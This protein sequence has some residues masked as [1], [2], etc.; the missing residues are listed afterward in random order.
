MYLY[1]AHENNVAEFLLVLDIFNPPHIP[2]YGSFIVVEVHLIDGVY[3]L[4]VIFCRIYDEKVGIILHVTREKCLSRIIKINL[5]ELS[6]FL[7][8][9]AYARSYIVDSFII[10]FSGLWIKSKSII[11]LPD[12]LVDLNL[13]VFFM[14]LM[15]S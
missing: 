11:N 3:G 7:N 8:V 5:I 13:R 4:K 6:T 12:I 2:T 15:I 1:S 9:R 14:K 10:R